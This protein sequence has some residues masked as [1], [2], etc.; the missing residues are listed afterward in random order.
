MRFSGR[1]EISLFINNLPTTLDK[2][3][4]K[5]IFYKAGRVNDVYIP[6]GKL[7]GSRKRY[8]FVRF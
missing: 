4:L 6:E 3:G 5:G 2:F 7:A 8:G 1:K